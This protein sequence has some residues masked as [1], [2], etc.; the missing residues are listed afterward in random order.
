MPVLA[1]YEKTEKMAD[2]RPIEILLVEDNDAD[3]MLTRA[4][5]EDAEVVHELH[6]AKDGEKALAFLK[7][8]GVYAHAKRPDIVLMDLKLPRMDGHEV[9]AEMQADAALRR[10][11]VIVLSGSG[12][13][14]DIR[15]SYEYHVAKHLVK[16][17]A[18]K[19][20][21]RIVRAIQELCRLPV[22]NGHELDGRPH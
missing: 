16:P 11:P 1:H 9:V 17:V 4:A 19:D 3:I 5:L 12:R 21:L 10:I 18:L 7:R 13:A 2:R 8:K 15:K 14:E 22:S 20:Y 6:V